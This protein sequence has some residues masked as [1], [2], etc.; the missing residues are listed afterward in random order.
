MKCSLFFCCDQ[1]TF[2]LLLPYLK[3]QLDKQ[4]SEQPEVHFSLG[5][6]LVDV[7]KN[8]CPSA[9]IFYLASALIRP[10]LI[11]QVMILLFRVIVE[12][13]AEFPQF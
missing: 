3:T 6:I 9:F 11:S 13:S 8:V 10:W 2:L 1:Q 7:P 12:M 4:K 5:S